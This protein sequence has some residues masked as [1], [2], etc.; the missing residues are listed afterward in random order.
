MK[1]SKIDTPFFSYKEKHLIEV[2]SYGFRG[3]VYYQSG[4]HGDWEF[5]GVQADIV[6]GEFHVLVQ[7]Q[8]EVN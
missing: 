6:L 2:I 1:K 3:S 5:G 8:Q 4:E 7:R